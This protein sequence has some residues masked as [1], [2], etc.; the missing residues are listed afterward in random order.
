M[1]LEHSDHLRR[2]A[3]ALATGDGADLRDRLQ[4]SGAEFWTAM[5]DYDL[6]PAAVRDAADA[7]LPRLFAGG[8]I[9][10][11]IAVMDEPALA[12]AADGLRRFF[13]AASPLL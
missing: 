12:A 1:I 5:F 4:R 11:T 3:A 7:V 6:W 13:D 10:E 2:A 9:R 8:L